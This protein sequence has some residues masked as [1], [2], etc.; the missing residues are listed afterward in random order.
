MSVM[1]PVAT[2]SMPQVPSTSTSRF[3]SARERREARRRRARHATVV[4]RLALLLLGIGL[5]GIATLRPF[6]L[7]AGESAVRTDTLVESVRIADGET[8]WDIAA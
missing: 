8:L 2:A 7:A 4:G 5:L 3:R 6:H 1:S